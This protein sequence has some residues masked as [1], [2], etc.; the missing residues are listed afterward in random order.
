MGDRISMSAGFCIKS[1]DRIQSRKPNFKVGK[2]LVFSP[3]P[4]GILVVCS[5]ARGR[6]EKNVLLSN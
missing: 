4:L 3:I 2:L 1:L 5:A 6:A